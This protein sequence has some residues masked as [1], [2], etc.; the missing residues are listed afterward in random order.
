MIEQEKRWWD[1]PAALCV[2]VLLW[3]PSL[4]LEV[5][6]WSNDLTRI[7]LIVLL[8][9][10]LG[11]GLGYSRLKGWLV[12]LLTI[13][14]SA[15]ILPWQLA[16]AADK[17]VV[18]KEA[19]ISLYHQIVVSIQQ[20]AANQPVDSPI[21]FLTGLALLFWMLGFFGGYAFTRHGRPWVPILL[22]ALVLGVINYFD[23]YS[24]H[25]HRYTGMFALISLL[26][27]GRLYYLKAARS[28]ARRGLNV[29]FDTGF[30][31]GRS[32]AVSGVVLVLAAWN[33]PFLFHMFTPGSAE[34]HKV[35]ETWQRWE[36]RFS[37]LVRGLQSPG[38][39][40]TEYGNNMD[41]GLG[42]NPGD[43]IIYTARLTGNKPANIRFYWRGYSYNTY[44]NG[45]WLNTMTDRQELSPARWPLTYPDW[46][47][48]TP[49][50]F[51]INIES[52]S[53]LTMYMPYAPLS[54]GRSTQVLGK[55]ADD[56]SF[57]LVS[58][59]ADP[60]M[61][62]GDTF[63][64]T[65]WVSTPT[66][67]QLR[68]AGEDYPEWIRTAYM[69]LPADFPARVGELAGEI[70]S[71][72]TSPYDQVMAVTA[73]LRNEITYQATIPPHPPGRDP[74]DWFLFDYQAGFCTYSASA[75]V[76]MLRSLGIPARLAVGYSQ[77]DMQDAGKY[78]QVRAK[79]SHTWV[80]VYFPGIGWVEFE[81]TSSEPATAYPQGS[82]AVEE[83]DELY[84][85]GGSIERATPDP[86]LDPAN[87][88]LDDVE[89]VTI[90]GETR[91]IS[92][93]NLVLMVIGGILVG[94]MIWMWLRRRNE[95]KDKSLPMV[96][97]ILL[98]IRGLT[99]PQWLR[100]WARRTTL[101]PIEKMFSEVT[102][103]I[104]I[105]GK[106]VKPGSTPAEQLTILGEIMPEAQ[107]P[108][109]QFLEEYQ[110][111]MYSPH[112]VNM[113]RAKSAYHQLWSI[114]RRRWGRKILGIRTGI[115]ENG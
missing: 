64:V 21:L 111:Y 81:P 89:D 47:G 12:A 30:S 51:V 101:A 77:G 18:L 114:T 109:K 48:R 6:E 104:R 40:G 14:T 91:G 27:L 112:P 22:G 16:L 13:T 95:W 57:D 73:Y 5:T 113:N 90:G 25:P 34:Q 61:R 72:L 19:F 96:L 43:E 67:P 54:V 1:I 79:N 46:T 45:E 63:R 7:E 88:E 10:A 24:K 74:V 102:W 17:S 44:I 93:L 75:D 70:T 49:V 99:A 9:T 107:S 108:A 55:S 87:Q 94:L 32:M 36:D 41:L 92:L 66:V 15:L 68:T 35:T 83:D 103:M 3:L 11:M 58:V 82:S 53:Q 110:K 29:D 115:P 26:L 2:L 71:G 56:G 37:N 65:S 31:I 106:R 38:Q 28:W 100:S 33:L 97:E 23:P 62:P 4:R 42:N 60:P 84:L 76:L 78:Y 86:A 59:I 20:F 98:D 105:L 52:G 69:Q 50:E 80:E 85:F 8:A 39:A